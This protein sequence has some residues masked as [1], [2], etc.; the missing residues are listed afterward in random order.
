[1][2]QNVKPSCDY[3]SKEVNGTM[4]RQMVGRLNYLTTTRPNISYYV[5]VLI[6]CMDK[7]HESHWNAAKEVHSYLKG[8]LDYGIKYTDAFDVEL[9][10]YSNYDWAGNL[11]DRRSS[12]RYAFSIGSRFVSWSS[13]K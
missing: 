12:T 2:Q 9:T 13:K 11:D 3:G 1:M 5:S 7:P 8:T 10:G 6:K 4:Y